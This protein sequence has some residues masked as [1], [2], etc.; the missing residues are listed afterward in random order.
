MRMANGS[1]PATK[2]ARHESTEWRELEHISGFHNHCATEA[3][4]GALPTGQNSPQHVAYG[5]F[6]EQLSGTA[7]TCPRA[8]NRRS[9][10]YRL[11]PS[12]RSLASVFALLAS[13][14]KRAA[15]SVALA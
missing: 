2:K 4:P 15:A 6:A 14:R 8:T 11:S 5:L 7:F 3:A 12:V 9:W 10:L 1:T 13:I